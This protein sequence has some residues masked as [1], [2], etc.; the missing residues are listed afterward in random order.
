MWAVIDQSLKVPKVCKLMPVFY[1][2]GLYY[3]P[4]FFFV[5]KRMTARN[6]L[7][8]TRTGNEDHAHN[9]DAESR[10]VGKWE[11]GQSIKWIR[12]GKKC[13]K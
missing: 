4:L 7:Y 1:S 3:A 9:L 2:K 11:N 10:V 13:V 6:L 8:D 5:G 12:D